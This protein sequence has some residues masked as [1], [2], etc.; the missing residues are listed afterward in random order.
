MTG[1]LP[2]GVDATLRRFL[3]AD[4]ADPIAGDLLEDR[5]PGGRPPLVAR[6]A[7]RSLAALRE[8]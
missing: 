7:C 5:G 3:P 6:D 1:R 2:R 8:N 4:L